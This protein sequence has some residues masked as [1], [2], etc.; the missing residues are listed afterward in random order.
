MIGADNDIG[1]AGVV[2][3]MRAGALLGN[4]ETL[5]LGGIVG[6]LLYFVLN[7]RSGLFDVKN[8]DSGIRFFRNLD[9]SS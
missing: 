2:A 1:Q 7:C 4:I 8:F 3:L 6:L 9:I 5:H